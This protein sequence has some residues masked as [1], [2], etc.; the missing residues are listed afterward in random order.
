MLV[1]RNTCCTASWGHRKR[2]RTPTKRPWVSQMIVGP[3]SS[4]TTA[5]Q[6]AKR[7]T[8][9]TARW[10][11]GSRRTCRGI[12]K[13][14]ITSAVVFAMPHPHGELREGDSKELFGRGCMYPL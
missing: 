13:R 3:A 14:N 6:L 11:G 1:S 10:C 5:P 2:W 12:R 4:T 7:S 9:R 8:H